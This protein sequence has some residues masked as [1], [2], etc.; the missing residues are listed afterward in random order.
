MTVARPGGPGVQLDE[1]WSFIQIKDASLE[2]A[3]WV[4]TTYGEIWVW[5]TFAPLWHLV[6]AFVVGQRTQANA[7]RLLQRVA[8]VTTDAIPFF[9]SD[10]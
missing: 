5:I 3:K 8:H 6:L 1:L 7:N 4:Y 9:T 10:Q 2:S